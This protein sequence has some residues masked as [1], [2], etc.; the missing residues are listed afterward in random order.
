MNKPEHYN[1]SIEPINVIDS[2]NLCFRL[3]NVAK[4][5]SRYKGK[6]GL[7]DLKKALDYLQDKIYQMEREQVK[8]ESNF[9]NMLKE[10]NDL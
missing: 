5:I 7:D 9:P 8:A 4:Y 3:G 10:S 1:L 6:N 2:W